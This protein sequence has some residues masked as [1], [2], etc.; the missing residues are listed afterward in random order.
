M[1]GELLF[2]VLPVFIIGFVGGFL[3]G[4]KDN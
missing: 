2:I 1:T 3:A 4:S